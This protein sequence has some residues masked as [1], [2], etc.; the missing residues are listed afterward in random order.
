VRPATARLPQGMTVRSRSVIVALLLMSLAAISMSSSTVRAAPPSLVIVS[1]VDGAIVANGTDVIVQFEVSNF[2]LTQPGRVGQVATPTEGQANVFVDGQYI[3][4]LTD[5]EPFSLPL[6]SGP[7][8]IR[9]QLVSSNGT[10]L[11]PDVSASVRVVATHGPAGGVPRIQ[12]VS[13]APLDSTPHDLY[14]SFRIANFTLVE[15]HGQPNAPNEGHLQVFVENVVVKEVVSYDPILLVAMPEGDITIGVRL[16]QN[17]GSPLTPDAAAS[18]LIRV[19]A[20]TAVSLP[21]VLNGGMAL[22][23]AFVLIV[24]LLRRRAAGAR[25]RHTRNGDP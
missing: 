23:L 1:P 10:P 20:S 2:T 7:H 4:L 25:S 9:M 17:D 19:V 12:I 16:V 6:N 8:T 5:V 3:R 21:L 22:L 13:P 15:P 24:L 18:V 11:A 14:L